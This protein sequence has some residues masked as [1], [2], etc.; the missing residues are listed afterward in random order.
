MNIY[1]YIYNIKKNGNKTLGLCLH[2][3]YHLLMS[4]GFSVV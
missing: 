1:I 2:A 3:A 4:Y